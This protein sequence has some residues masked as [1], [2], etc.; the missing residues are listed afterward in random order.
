MNIFMKEQLKNN[1]LAKRRSALICAS[2]CVN[3]R[4]TDKNF[5][6]INADLKRRYARMI[7]CEDLCLNL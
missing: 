4:E 3:Q 5:S 7:L 1:E 2:I 6:Q